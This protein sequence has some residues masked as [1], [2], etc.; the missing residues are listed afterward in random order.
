MNILCE[1]K[2]AN[3]CRL[4]SAFGFE[5]GW[6]RARETKSMQKYPPHVHPDWLFVCVCVF[7]TSCETQHAYISNIRIC[8]FGRAYLLLN[9]KAIGAEQ[10]QMMG[11]I[12][13]CCS[14]SKP[15]KLRFQSQSWCQSNHS[16]NTT[17]LQ[18]QMYLNDFRIT[19]SS[20]IYLY[21]YTKVSYLFD[22]KLKH[23]IFFDSEHNTS[24]N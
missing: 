16:A 1:L 18:A 5:R 7:V 15:P 3:T 9:V 14:L 23:Q 10:R 8:L 13:Q 4:K 12:N 17:R 20:C 2:G 24:R 6:S 19:F 22:L 21:S 11:F